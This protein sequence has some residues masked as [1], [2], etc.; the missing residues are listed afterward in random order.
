LIIEL[1]P[2]CGT[3][4]AACTKTFDILDI[5]NSFSFLE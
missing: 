5:L 3:L 4:N 1:D 2:A